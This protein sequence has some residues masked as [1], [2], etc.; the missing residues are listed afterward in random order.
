[1]EEGTERRGNLGYKRRELR[2][3][4]EVVHILEAHTREGR[5]TERRG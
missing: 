3:N 2:D 4:R 1:M 5:D